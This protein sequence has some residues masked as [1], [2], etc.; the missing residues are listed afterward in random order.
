MENHGFVVDRFSH[1]DQS[2]DC[3]FNPPLPT[4]N[5]PLESQDLWDHESPVHQGASE[6][7]GDLLGFDLTTK[8]GDWIGFHQGKLVIYW[9]LSIMTDIYRHVNQ[10]KTVNLIDKNWLI[11]FGGTTRWAPKRQKSCLTTEFVFFK[12]RSFALFL[13]LVVVYLWRI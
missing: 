4:Q 2:I 12:P 13:N 3:S 9:D 8:N 10:Q 7:H 5:S 6:K 11:F 1:L